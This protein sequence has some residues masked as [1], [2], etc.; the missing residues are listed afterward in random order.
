MITKPDAP[1][2]PYLTDCYDKISLITFDLLATWFISLLNYQ[3][4]T[5]IYCNKSK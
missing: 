1:N 3:N 2:F 4:L 5:N